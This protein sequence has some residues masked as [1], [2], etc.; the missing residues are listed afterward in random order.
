MDGKTITIQAAALG[1]I[2]NEIEHNCNMLVLSDEEMSADDVGFY[3]PRIQRAAYELRRLIR[4]AAPAKPP[5]N[6]N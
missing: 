3:V 4:T 5:V 2:L 1:A 6:N